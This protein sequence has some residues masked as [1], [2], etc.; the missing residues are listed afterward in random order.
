MGNVR[1]IVVDVDPIWT[2]QLK[3]MLNKMGYLVVGEASDGPSAL[4]LARTRQPDLVI[5]HDNLPGFSGLEVARIMYEDKI[6]PVIITTDF[7]QPNLV[8]KARE[9]RVFHVIQKPLDDRDLLPAVELAL[10]NYQEIIKL[11]KKIKDLR[12]TL[13]SRK[14]VEK[15][16]GIL[17]KAMGLT[18]EEAFKKIQ[19]QSMNKR[20]SMRAV[21]EAIILA[22]TINLE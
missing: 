11:E 12:E 6:G 13:E 22:H 14:L 5:T 2:K 18:E 4:K 19:R 21:A 17:M 1:I 8:E 7:L 16:K 20:I 3:T 10:G 15:A 9:I